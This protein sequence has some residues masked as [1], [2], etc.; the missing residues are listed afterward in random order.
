MVSKYGEETLATLESAWSKTSPAKQ[1]E[2]E[3]M[4]DF[5]SGL[6]RLPMLP[7]VFAEAF[8]PDPGSRLGIKPKRRA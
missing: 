1:P 7:A 5:L 6:A 4:V 3:E 2:L 8:D